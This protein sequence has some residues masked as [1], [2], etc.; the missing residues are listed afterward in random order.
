MIIQ[1]S[2]DLLTEPFRGQIRGLLAEAMERRV[3][4]V[5]TETLRTYE[6]QQLLFADRKSRTMRS[7]HVTGK[8]VDVGVVKSYSNMT[9]GEVTWD[10]RDSAWI[11]LGELA[12]KWGIGWGGSRKGKW[13]DFEDFPHLEALA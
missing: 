3:Y 1:T 10:K 8:A 4:F 7:N 5:V 11:V 2:L 9:V 6:R 12:L 13:A